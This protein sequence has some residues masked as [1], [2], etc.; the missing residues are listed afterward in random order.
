MDDPKHHEDNDTIR[1]S[2]LSWWLFLIAAVLAIPSLGFVIVTVAG[3]K[4]AMGIIVFMVCCWSA[5]YFG[6]HLV[7]HPNMH[8]K[9]DLTK[10]N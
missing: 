6:M 7:S 8:K 9:K 1:W 4:G 2:A 3:I 10:R 5:T